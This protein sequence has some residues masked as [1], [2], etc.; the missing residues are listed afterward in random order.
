MSGVKF[1]TPEEIMASMPYPELTTFD[2][3]PNYKLL[4]T[5][6]NGIKENCASIPSFAGG[7]DNGYLGVI[8]SNA[9]YAIVCDTAFTVPED[10]GTLTLEAGTTAVDSNNKNRAHTEN[11]R[12]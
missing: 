9:A 5:I 10:P 6:R 8:M 3:E 7:G 1:Q 2:G 11:K 12:F 4:V